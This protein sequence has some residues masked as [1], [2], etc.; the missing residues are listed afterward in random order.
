MSR[1]TTLGTG[2]RSRCSVAAAAAVVAVAAMLVLPG[3]AHAAYRHRAESGYDTT[4]S[5]S[6]TATC[7]PGEELI[8]AGGRIRNGNG[9]VRLAAIVPGTTSVV[10]RGEAYPGHAE[11]WSVIAA[12]I[13]APDDGTPRVVEVSPAGSRTASCPTDLVLSGTGFDLPAGVPLAGLV[14]DADGASVTVR[15]A[16]HQLGTGPVAYAICV[17]GIRAS[18]AIDGARYK[19]FATTSPGGT[20]SPRMVTVQREWEDEFPSMSGVGGEITALPDPADLFPAPVS[21]IFIDA[22]MPNDD[23]SQVTVAAVRRAAVGAGPS[24]GGDAAAAGNGLRSVDRHSVDDDTLW[25]VTGYSTD[26]D[27]Y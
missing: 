15:T 14:P 11:P 1:D 16:F 17:Q 9:G 22:M 20:S 27:I 12:A 5:K 6:V 10:V 19:R 3:T 25:T 24:V 2:T 21:D 18:S 13:C 23:G 4:S 26:H 8:G 7:G